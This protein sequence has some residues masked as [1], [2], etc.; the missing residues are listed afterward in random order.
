MKTQHRASDPQIPLYL[1]VISIAVA[2]SNGSNGG[3][4]GSTS[5]SGGTASSGSPGAGTASGSG[6]GSTSSSGSASGAESS[7]GGS[8]ASGSGGGATASSGGSG[9]GQASGSGSTG[10]SGPS[11]SSGGSATAVKSNGCGKTSTVTFG[12]VPN[13]NPNAAAGSG[14]GVGTGQGGYVT[15][16]DSKAGG[17]RGFAIRLPDHYDDAKPY[18]LIFDFHW[19]GGNSAQVDNGGTSGY[20]FAYYGLQSNSKNGAIFVGPDS[21]GAGWSNSNDQDLH[22][23]DDMVKLITDNYC[24]DTSNII[25]TGFSWGGGMSYELACARADPSVAGYAFRAAVIY[26]GANL[27]G[28]DM[29]GKHPIALWQK[30]GLTDTTCPVSLAKPIRDQFVMNNGCTGWTSDQTPLQTSTNVST[31]PPEPPA[32]GQYLNPGGHIC[33]NYTGCSAGHPIRW[34]VDQSGHG[35]GSVDGTSD[36]YQSCAKAPSQCSSSC[37]CSWTADDVWTWLND[38]SSNTHSP[39][40]TSE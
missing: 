9:S 2:C 39:N 19:N 20:Q 26:E 33:T 10:D 27:S 7:G 17:S 36:L 18:W 34:C 15:L 5:G 32:P 13:E 12:S 16:N 35:P 24:V 31:E 6:T 4:T 38:P 25:T 23:T 28:C 14:N 3:S 30:V 37:P 22:F 1:V 29:S 11:G 8:G 21:I 40:A